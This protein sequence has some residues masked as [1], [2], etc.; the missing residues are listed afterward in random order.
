MANPFQFSIRRMLGAVAL[1]LRGDAVSVAALGLNK[2]SWTCWPA[3]LFWLF[4]SR[5]RGDWVY[6]RQAIHWRTYGILCRDFIRRYMGNSLSDFLNLQ[7]RHGINSR[8]TPC[9]GSR[10]CDWPR[11]AVVV[12][13][14]A[15]PEKI[16]RRPW[17]ASPHPGLGKPCGSAGPVPISRS[18]CRHHRAVLAM[19]HASVAWPGFRRPISNGIAPGVSPLLPCSAPLARMPAWPTRRTPLNRGSRAAA[20]FN[21]GCGRCSWASC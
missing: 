13:E 10:R 19:N 1:I 3:F 15:G 5:R 16:F 4:H 18:G 11:A 14:L 17:I 6:T 9:R 21:S 12:E 20:G 7:C 2:R 8:R